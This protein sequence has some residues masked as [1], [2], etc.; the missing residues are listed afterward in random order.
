MARPKLAQCF[1]ARAARRTARRRQG[2]RPPL[3]P[4]KVV[5]RRR[6]DTRNSRFDSLR[7]PPAFPQ[8]LRL[9]TRKTSMFIN[10]W[11]RFAAGTIRILPIARF[12][13]ARGSSAAKRGHNRS[14]INPRA[15]RFLTISQLF[16]ARS[17][18][19]NAAN[20]SQSNFRSVSSRK[21]PSTSAAPLTPP[22]GQAHAPGILS[23]YQCYGRT[24]PQ[25]QEKH[26]LGPVLPP[27]THSQLLSMLWSVPRRRQ[28]H[29]KQEPGP[30]RTTSPYSHF[31]SMLWI[32]GRFPQPE[33][34]LK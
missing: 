15:G 10:V 31:L 7:L 11:A 22:K 20:Q 12:F 17:S 23:F 14:A 9:G 25:I 16:A 1:D 18:T 8:A 21:G 34:R 6:Q 2:R 28:M 29:E 27:P 32:A 3:I 33:G 26:E 4:C 13:E 30:L 5:L 24:Q 19:R